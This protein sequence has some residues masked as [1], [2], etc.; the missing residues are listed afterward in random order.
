MGAP[1]EAETVRSQLLDLTAQLEQDQAHSSDIIS[2]QTEELE[3]A[4]KKVEEGSEQQRKMK[5]RMA[6]LQNELE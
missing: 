3:E 2:K 1:S 4:K 6:D 5:A